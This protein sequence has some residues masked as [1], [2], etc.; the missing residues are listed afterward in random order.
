MNYTKKIGN[1]NHVI[2]GSPPP[3][4]AW[5]VDPEAVTGAEVTRTGDTL[6]LAL[7][8][9]TRGMAGE[10]TCSADNGF[11]DTPVTKSVKVCIWG[12]FENMFLNI[13]CDPGQC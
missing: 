1:W 7:T 2:S 8:Q 5:D 3:D 9:V 11:Q 4:L 6:R 13:Y 12:S 10:M